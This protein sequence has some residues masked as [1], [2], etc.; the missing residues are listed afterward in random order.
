[1]TYQK[2]MER[3]TLEL[4][5]LKIKIEQFRDY[6]FTRVPEGRTGLIHEYINLDIEKKFDE[7]FGEKTVPAEESEK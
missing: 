1:M 7:I 3:L 2:E 6:L 5:T 4:S